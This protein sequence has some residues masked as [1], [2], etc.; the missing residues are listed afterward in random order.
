MTLSRFF[1]SAER[2]F[3]NGIEEVPA[4]FVFLFVVVVELLFLFVDDDVG[5]EA[6]FGIVDDDIDLSCRGF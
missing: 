4:R 2:V 1:L 5:F 3:V 6:Y